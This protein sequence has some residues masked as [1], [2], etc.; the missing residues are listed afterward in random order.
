MEH[1]SGEKNMRLKNSILARL[2]IV[3]LTV[4]LVVPNSFTFAEDV[5]TDRSASNAAVEETVTDA[6][7]QPEATADQ[8]VTGTVTEKQKTDEDS[9]EADKDD[10]KVEASKDEG[11]S[12]KSESASDENADRK[13][14]ETSGDQK[15]DAAEDETKDAVITLK[16]ISAASGSPLT[17]DQTGEGFTFT[18]FMYPASLDLDGKTHEEVMKILKDYRHEVKVREQGQE[19]TTRKPSDASAS[20]KYFIKGGI[21]SEEDADRGY[22]MDMWDGAFYAVFGDSLE[23]EGITDGGKAI[24][25][26][27]QIK[28]DKEGNRYFEFVKYEGFDK[29][30]V[31]KVNVKGGADDDFPVYLK[32]QVTADM[33]PDTAEDTVQKK[34]YTD[35][36]TKN[37]KTEIKLS[38]MPFYSTEA[39]YSIKVTAYTDENCTEKLD[40]WYSKNPLLDKEIT[41][42]SSEKPS[43]D[44]AVE[45]VKEK[46][47]QKDTAAAKKAPA[48]APGDVVTP[49]LTV[50]A[51][52]FDYAAAQSLPSKHR[53]TITVE[54]SADTGGNRYIFS[55]DIT[56]VTE[57]F[58]GA[59][60]I[61]PGKY[62]ITS[63]VVSGTDKDNWQFRS[64]PTGTS[65]YF[66]ADGG[67]FYDEA[68]S[69]PAEFVLDYTG[70]YDMDIKLNVI[71]KDDGHSLTAAEI[72]SGKDI[73]YVAEWA[74]SAF[75]NLDP[76][77]DGFVSSAMFQKYGKKFRVTQQGQTLSIE[78]PKSPEGYEDDTFI[79]AASSPEI[80]SESYGNGMQKEYP[81]RDAEI[82]YFGSAYFSYG[83]GQCSYTEYSS[84][85]PQWSMHKDGDDIVMD[86]VVDSDLLDT[87]SI[88]VVS[89]GPAD[90]FPVY[91]EVT[92]QRRTTSDIHKPSGSSAN[93][94]N[95]MT[96]LFGEP[97]VLTDTI[98]VDAP[99]EVDL[100]L[101][102]K[103][104]NDKS[105]YYLT[106]RVVD[107]HG[108]YDE[109]WDKNGEEY[110]NRNEEG[111][112]W[113]V[114]H[115]KGYN[116]EN[117]YTNYSNG[118]AVI[119]F[120]YAKVDSV[121]LPLHTEFAE[122]TDTSKF[123]PVYLKAEMTLESGSQKTYTAVKKIESLE[124]ANSFLLF[125]EAMPKG[126][127][128]Y[129]N[130]SFYNDEELTELSDLWQSGSKMVTIDDQNRLVEGYSYGGSYVPEA[131][132]LRF[133]QMGTYYDVTADDTPEG[134]FPKYL[135]IN[136][137]AYGSGEESL[138]VVRKVDK[139]G[140]QGTAYFDFMAS[141]GSDWVV[142][143]KMYNEMDSEGNVSDE[144]TL[145][146]NHTYYYDSSYSGNSDRARINGSGLLNTYWGSN[147]YLIT[148][149]GHFVV[150]PIWRGVNLV[151]IPVRT[152][153][154]EGLE[155]EAFRYYPNPGQRLNVSLSKVGESS[156]S[157]PVSNSRSTTSS[158]HE[159]GNSTVVFS[160][161]QPG[162]YYLTYNTSRFYQQNTWYS[163]WP[164]VQGWKESAEGGDRITITSDGR[165]LDEDE[166]EYYIDNRYVGCIPDGNPHIF[167]NSTVL[168]G[169][170]DVNTRLYVELKGVK[171]TDT[172]KITRRSSVRVD[173]DHLG[174]FG[175]YY[176]SYYSEDPNTD[177]NYYFF[178]SSDGGVGGSSYAR[179]L[180]AG[181]YD[182]SYWTADDREPDDSDG[183]RHSKAWVEDS[184]IRI[185]IDE[186]GN[187]TK[188]GEPYVIPNYMLPSLD[189]VT[190]DIETTVTEG[191]KNAF[192]DGNQ[193][194]AYL[195][196]NNGNR[197]ASGSTEVTSTGTKSITLT[198]E[199]GKKI[200]PGMGPASDTGT[201]VRYYVTFETTDEDGVPNRYWHSRAYS[202]TDTKNGRIPVYVYPDGSVSDSSKMG[203]YYYDSTHTELALTKLV[204]DNYSLLLPFEGNEKPDS[205][206][207]A[208]NGQ[209]K[210]ETI[211]NTG[212][213]ADKSHYMIVIRNKYD[214][215]FYAVSYAD[216][217]GDQVLL[218]DVNSLE[219][220]E[221]GYLLNES[222]L[223]SKPYIFTAN[224]TSYSEG[225]VSTQ[226]RSGVKD[227]SGKYM[228]MKL[229][230][231]AK[232]YLPLMANSAGTLTVRKEYDDTADTACFTINKNNYSFLGYVCEFLGFSG[233]TVYSNRYPS[234]PT[235]Y[236]MTYL[237]TSEKFFYSGSK[238]VD[239]AETTAGRV[240]FAKKPLS[241]SEA[242][243]F[244]YEV[245]PKYATLEYY[246][247]LPGDIAGSIAE[248]GV[249]SP[250]DDEV[251]ILTDNQQ[252]VEETPNNSYKLVKTFGDFNKT[253]SSGAETSMVMVYT[254][255]D[256][257]EYALNPKG[258]VQ[259]RTK[260]GSADYRTLT[261][262]ADNEFIA[263]NNCRTWY[264]NKYVTY[265]GMNP[266][267]V[268]GSNNQVFTGVYS[269]RK[270]RSNTYADGEYLTM[271]GSVMGPDDSNYD[272]NDQIYIMHPTANVRNQ[273]DWD[274][275]TSYRLSVMRGGKEYW[276]GVE[277]GQM[278]VVENE[279]DAVVFDVY[280]PSVERYYPASASDDFN[281]Y[282]KISS[283][284]DINAD[285][286]IVIVYNHD[287]KKQIVACTTSESGFS[288]EKGYT[289]S[290]Y[291]SVYVSDED[292]PIDTT[293]T[294][295]FPK[296]FKY[297]YRLDTTNE[298]KHVYAY[299][300]SD[301][302][303]MAQGGAT[304]AIGSAKSA[305]KKQEK[306]DSVVGLGQNATQKLWIKEPGWTDSLY[307]GQKAEVNFFFEDGQFYLRGGKSDAW[308]GNARYSRSVY[309][310]NTG[311]YSTEVHDHF[312]TVEK[313]NRVPVEIYK[314]G[315]LET[316]KVNY[317]DVNDLDGAPAKTETKPEGM[318]GLPQEEDVEHNDEDYIFVGWTKDKEKTGYLSKDESTNIF[319]FDDISRTASVREELREER[320][321]LGDCDP[322]ASNTI[323]IKA[324]DLEDNTLDLYRYM[325]TAAGPR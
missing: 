7:D 166:N 133:Y 232:E 158:I 203:Y 299:E 106:W 280:A 220:L 84:S 53:F 254:A 286:E 77:T 97:E 293:G 212:K 176:R 164:K 3:V 316:I 110:V 163:W 139:A 117:Y 54:L 25:K 30:P 104:L 127:T 64:D 46:E 242:N 245:D 31:I 243:A 56:K 168:D 43:D 259:V 4:L 143:T 134:F 128:F 58:E 295:E 112:L 160:S 180:P 190:F 318:I 14:G 60:A 294:A 216:G 18:Y 311:K 191:V 185:H 253:F 312:L 265:F 173:D 81:T 62:R 96:T 322:E 115:Y 284:D 199:P 68:C 205:V 193:V 122:G 305:N 16:L 9:Q 200:T 66:D 45:L 263:N 255:P 154:K 32:T 114:Y 52:Y 306:Y 270:S 13:A 35:K 86:V 119:W 179:T 217:K 28:E 248:T 146:R 290:L 94:C 8:N 201:N 121:K 228:S 181:D 170:T 175:Y 264:G 269:M 239:I 247:S 74:Q 149:D 226:F 124:D 171:G 211:N 5:Y 221:N 260:D 10:G 314:R 51:P 261:A 165:V 276:L 27:N 83:T 78:V 219:D 125:N 135:S 65:V 39:E 101:S 136:V 37:G 23:T 267:D 126:E 307:Y 113:D 174:L 258:L 251:Y 218:E 237:P 287:G 208:E 195:Y 57:D 70:T 223:G 36:A 47:D 144:D 147:S 172:D 100:P 282:Y 233:F 275:A 309:D 236:M 21:H 76:V 162:D 109:D 283:L 17:A 256:G 281:P 19:L 11:A 291:P 310:S 325:H 123:F 278:T 313:N 44:L 92:M 116:Y 192:R 6:Q 268:S 80:Y 129:L 274:K 73:N 140:Q 323:K 85:Q 182:L 98:R 315:T 105:A 292:V 184:G 50:H 235:I 240:Y 38:G 26:E 102:F 152:T 317:Y 271:N 250:M 214:G 227:D 187:V 272:Y 87:P 178:T 234:D 120:R 196:D 231:S 59:K 22:S 89:S 321:L 82:F 41:F 72:G 209:I 302:M 177:G 107:E 301:S 137:R 285:D 324:S 206:K 213:I 61:T 198:A 145:W 75:T 277:D 297:Y 222:D 238:Y 320:G 99:G 279:A 224:K 48:K 132:A 273:V 12:E 300:V 257:K 204:L 249:F 225:S 288:E 229:G 156:Y 252:V 63:A 308:L 161:L 207:Q 88:K 142:G 148:R 24:K 296:D 230:T 91:V 303:I 319:D 202:S 15:G 93:A 246:Q 29:A 215:K 20:N 141:E 33:T 244:V 183:N 131:A 197:I 157:S 118:E 111:K 153:V 130:W 189:S 150:D 67:M 108:D 210:F 79:F 188:D 55:R 95:K 262:G 241:S 34:E 186:N 167:V 266:I 138:T 2:T 103:T 159:V 151:S 155:D 304:N 298:V 1:I 49:I 90:K 169:V 42:D 40:S 194:H 289:Y 69:E 71:D